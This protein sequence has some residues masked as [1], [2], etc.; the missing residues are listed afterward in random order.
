MIGLK[1]NVFDYL[2]YLLLLCL[3]F[4]K[5][6]P[7]IILIPVS[8]LFLKDVFT[9]KSSVRILPL[10]FLLLLFLY[11]FVKAL[12]LGT[13]V[14][15]Q[16]IYSGYLLVVWLLLLLQNVKDLNRFKFA[17]LVTFSLSVYASFIM[18][19]KYYLHSHTLPF[20]NTAEA[21]MLLVLE[22]PY[23]GITAVFGFFLSIDFSITLRKY[24]WWIRT[25][26][27]LM[28]LFIILISAR[29]SL[30]T[31]FLMAAVF[32]VFY[33][34]VGKYNKIGALLLLV[35]TF[36]GLLLVNQNISK[37]FFIEEN[38]EK[39]IE[40]AAAYEPR[41]VIWNCA[42]NMSQVPEFNNILGWGSYQS[43]AWNYHQCYSQ[44]IQDSSKRGYFLEENFNSHNQFIDFYLIGGATA[45]LLFTAFILHFFIQVKKDFFATALFVAFV[46]FFFL[47]NVLY[48]QF[49]CYLFSIFTALYMKKGK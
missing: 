2:L 21:N 10:V 37:R 7:N 39:S 44:T 31:V 41:V 49:G 43:I 1:K 14:A 3:P 27:G 12:F 6:V 35:F 48:R 25:N 38:L 4:F 22:R 28:L 46:L 36:G 26:A 40:V 34:K 42:M 23:A 13:F 33:Y 8:L 18:M 9:Q 16:R 15:D 24:R 47:E 17:V 29:L 20:G 19:A 45:L 30:V 11:L 32:F 5:G